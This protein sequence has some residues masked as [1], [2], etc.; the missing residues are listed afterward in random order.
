MV[1][2]T[3]SS[4][5]VIQPYPDSYDLT[6]PLECQE[7]CNDSLTLP[8]IRHLSS[9][10]IRTIIEFCYDGRPSLKP[11]QFS[12]IRRM[13]RFIKTAPFLEHFALDLYCDFHGLRDGFPISLIDWSPLAHFVAECPSSL[14]NLRIRSD[15]APGDDDVVHP[16]I[17]ASFSGCGGLVQMV[18]EGRLVVTPSILAGEG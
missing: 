12:S 11:F 16:D 9:L 7:F 5:L 17:L 15:E 14:V 8:G 2:L 6:I 10:T 18:N 1:R 3:I 13:A 4:L